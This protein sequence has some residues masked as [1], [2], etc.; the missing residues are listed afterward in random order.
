MG[1]THTLVKAPGATPRRWML[2]LHGLLG[3][4]S[5]WRGVATRLVE[6]RPEWGAVL[7]DLRM[8]GG[9][10]QGFKPPHTVAAAAE[11]LRSLDAV[12]PGPV[13][14][15]LGHSF[16]GKVALSYLEGRAHALEQ[17]WVI[18]AMPGRKSPERASNTLAVLDFLSS[19]PPSLPSREEFVER[20][21][22]A[23]FE[24]AIAQWLAQNL[25]RAGD[26]FKLAVDLA[27]IRELLDDY[28][29]T[30]RW[31]I[32]ERPPAPT[33]LHVVIG[34]RSPVFPAADRERLLQAARTGPRLHVHTLPTGHWV[35]VEEPFS[36]VA[37]IQQHLPR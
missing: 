12:V 7:V 34:E 17:A 31:S 23:G 8:H 14:A 28:F 1:L 22:G 2:F 37:L 33:T 36:L 3:R 21:T 9:S 29:V 24:S 25:A 15:V 13:R 19:L 6:G 4:G 32:A 18:D 30:D 5:N 10:Q 11:D 20:A 26:G 16:G 27:A 35:H